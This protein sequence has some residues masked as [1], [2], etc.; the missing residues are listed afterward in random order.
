MW[1]RA[2]LVQPLTTPKVYSAVTAF[3]PVRGDEVSN[4]A[5]QDVEFTAAR[6]VFAKLESGKEYLIRV[7]RIDGAMP[8]DKDPLVPSW[9]SRRYFVRVE[10]V[11]V[12]VER[13]PEH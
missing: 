12:Q 9:M 6:E 2:L 7:R 3:D 13:M 8:E 5:R 11:E 1:Q 10:Y 4:W